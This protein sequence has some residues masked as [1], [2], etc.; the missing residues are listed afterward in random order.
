[1]MTKDELKLKVI[2]FL[3][4]WKSEIAVLLGIV[5]MIFC[6]NF[7]MTVGKDSTDP[8]SGRSGLI[9][10]IDAKTGCHYVK[11]GIF[12]ATTPRLNQNGKQICAG[13]ENADDKP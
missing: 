3:I 2:Y 12:G 1:M 4:H 7:M 6:V 11:G 5:V 13:A 9:L 8:E 10:Y